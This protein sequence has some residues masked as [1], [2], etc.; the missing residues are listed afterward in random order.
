MKLNQLLKG[1]YE[2]FKPDPKFELHGTNMDPY[3]IY[4]KD[5]EPLIEGLM[6]CEEFKDVTKIHIL[7]KPGPGM[8]DFK[9]KTINEGEVKIEPVYDIDDLTPSTQTYKLIPTTK[10]AGEIYLWS[11]NL[12]PARLNPKKFNFK[13]WLC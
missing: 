3:N 1:I 9:Y 10:L 11:I 13:E 12:S 7:D 6:K 4:G 8:V 5:L 2:N